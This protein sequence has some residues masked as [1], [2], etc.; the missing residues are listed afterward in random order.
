MRHILC[1][2]M[3]AKKHRRN[4]RRKYAWQCWSDYTIDFRHFILRLWLFIEL[5]DNDA[6]RNVNFKASQQ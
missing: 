6:R 1:V 5:G 3:I 2:P 4:L